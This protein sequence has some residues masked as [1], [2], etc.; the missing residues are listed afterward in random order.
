MATT[1]NHNDGDDRTHQGLISSPLA[2]EKI[3]TA[4]FNTWN[5]PLVASC[6]L[7]TWF[8]CIGLLQIQACIARGASC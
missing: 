6:G 7:T 8:H 4:T 1:L 5:A 2:F 3:V